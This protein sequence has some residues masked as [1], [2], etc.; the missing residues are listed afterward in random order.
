[1]PR[2]TQHKQQTSLNWSDNTELVGL[3]FELSPQENAY[4]YP[5][6]TIGL[7]AWFLDQ[8]RSHNSELSAYLHN[9]ESEKP[10]TISSLEGALS[11]TG[12]QL[13]LQSD[14][15]YLWYVTVLSQ[16]VVQWL[17]SWVQQ[18][19]DVLELRNAPL[20]IKSCQIALPP[21]TYL[22]LFHHSPKS[23][24]LTL[25]FLTPTSFRR[26][27]HHLPLPIPVNVFHSYLRRWN[28]FSGKEYNFEEFLE[29]VDEGVIIHRHQLESLKVAAGKKGSVTGFT[30]AI[31]YGLSQAAQENVEFTQLFYSLGELAPYC[32]TGHK[33]TFGLGQ[34]R[35]GWIGKT[36]PVANSVENVLAQRISELTSLLMSEQKRTG[37]SRAQSVCE[38]RATILARREMGESLLAIAQDLE[39][40]YETV[41][42]Y[43]K[44]ARRALT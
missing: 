36:E 20:K 41:K 13:Q 4:V 32:G 16:R 40:P 31:E 27:G 11:S 6:Y 18:L 24:T 14:Q 2:K 17:A 3:V 29:W 15:T 26:K 7:H 19:P 44:L 23:S 28:D 42:T 34:T 38:T 35:L 22:D 25:S 12:K 37:G 21:T 10:F 1:M 9:G 8:V 43:A 30:G 5:Q 33:T 39:M